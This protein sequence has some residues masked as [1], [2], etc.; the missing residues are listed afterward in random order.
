MYLIICEQPI[1]LLVSFLDLK[2]MPGFFSSRKSAFGFAFKGIR[3][4]FKETHARLHL[5]VAILVVLAGIFFHLQALEWCLV[6]LCIG[7]V[8]CAEAFN[9]AIERI[10]NKISPEH[11]IEAGR[12]KDIAAGA[13][14]LLCIFAA[15]IGLLL[16]V[17]KIILLF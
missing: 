10:V 17:P 5:L 2:N 1:S 8:W 13:V 9:S 16:F 15:L 6:F 14:L 7:A 12:I 4:F 3:L 11:N